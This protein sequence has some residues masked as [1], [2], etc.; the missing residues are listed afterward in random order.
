MDTQPDK[1]YDAIIIG[2]GIGGLAT[3]I[4][5]AQLK[6]SVLLLEQHIT[7]GGYVCGFKRKG[8]YF[9]G[10][11][12]S[13]SSHGIVFPILEEL[14]V[15]NRIKWN[16]HRISVKVP[17]CGLSFQYDSIHSFK[18]AIRNVFSKEKNIE[19][20]LNVIGDFYNFFKL[21]EKYPVPTIYFGL[22][23]LLVTFGFFKIL[24]E[25]NIFR[26]LKT[27]FKYGKLSTLDFAARFF[28]KESAAF[29][30]FSSYGSPTQSSIIMGAMILEF[31]EDKWYPEGGE[32]HFADVLAARAEELGVT[33]LYKTLAEKIITRKGKAVGVKTKQAQYSAKYIISDSDYR[34]TFNEMLDDQSILP[35]RF[36]KRLDSARLSESLFNV[37]IGVKY[38]KAELEKIL[39]G[40]HI[41]FY[42]ALNPLDIAKQTGN[43]DF[44]KD[45]SLSIFSPS[46]IDPALAPAGKQSIIVQTLSP[47]YWMDNWGGADKEQYRALKQKVTEQ[48]MDSLSQLIP[49]VKERLEV[50]DAATARTYERYTFNSGG[51]YCAWNWQSGKSFWKDLKMHNETPVKNLFFCSDWGYKVGGMCA[52]LILAK[53]LWWAFKKT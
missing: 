34:Y 24:R 40:N 41:M 32:Q 17:E 43:P 53:Q 44:F 50:F 14:G 12:T 1:R 38:S 37:Y 31:I 7:P 33:I 42:P 2:A 47:N 35:V 29:K 21:L 4:Y 5:L 39:N 6:R 46:L 3:A 26:I 13:F 49:D 9:D 30:Y 11:N 8:Y 28:N 19:T 48:I 10:A 16:L 51:A 36:R 22:K 52:A 27:I 15:K 45:M 25:K 23:K 20:F 18:E